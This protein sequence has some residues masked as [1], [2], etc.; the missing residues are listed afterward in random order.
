M[1]KLL[2][3]LFMRPT[4]TTHSREVNSHEY[5]RKTSLTSIPSFLK[6]CLGKIIRNP[7]PGLG[8]FRKKH[9]AIFKKTKHGNSVIATRAVQGMVPR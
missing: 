4:S 1:K 9:L 3:N 5:G 2:R 7:F 6:F 8:G